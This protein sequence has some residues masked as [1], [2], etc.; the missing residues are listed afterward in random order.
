MSLDRELAFARKWM[1]DGATLTE[2][3][4]DASTRRFYRVRS[5]PKT[6]VLIA[7]GQPLP[8]DAP[9]FSNHRILESIGAPVPSL[10]ARSE[11]DG[12]VLVEDFG[13]VTLQQHLSGPATLSR[14]GD[15][16]SQACDL[17]GLLQSRAPEAIQKDDFAARNA[18][19]RERFLFE[20][21][22]FQRHFI[23]GLRGLKPAG[24]DA[25][26][27]RAFYEDLA[28]SCDLQARVYC[29]RDY[30]SRNLMVLDGRIRLIDFQ[31]ARMGP[32]TYDSAS[33]LRDSSLDI[34]S[35][36]VE[37]SLDALLS[38]TAAP[39]GIGREEFRSDFD[40]MALQR[41]VKDLG[42]FGFMAT[43]RGRREYL[44]YIPRT[45]ASIRRTLVGDRRWHD[46]FGTIDRFVLDWTP[47]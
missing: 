23:E 33:L 32:Y 36:L 34:E 5:D 15:L 12:L 29:H 16:Y 35:D 40:V 13:D 18:L 22:H 46:L 14:A 4:G 42:T 11:P 28:S 20:L 2:I 45:I 30:Q 37:R 10:L 38:R 39:L 3:A 21:D 8:G 44:G 9:F 24:S 17:I 27:L 41:N 26:L 47:D 25:A 19:D 43:V 1:G 31:D 7:H 6:A